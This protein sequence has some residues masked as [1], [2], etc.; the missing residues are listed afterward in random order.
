MENVESHNNKV[1]S[2]YLAALNRQN[3]SSRTIELYGYVL[4][5]FDAGTGEKPVP[6][7]TIDDLELYRL[8][9]VERDMTP[10]S[11]DV[12]MRVVR[13]FF[14]WLEDKQLIFDNPAKGLYLPMP[15]RKLMKVPSEADVRRLLAHPNPATPTGIR[16]RAL[17]ETMYGCGLRR[18]EVLSLTIFNLDLAFGNLRV[19]GK[20]RRERTLPLGRHA[21]RWLKTYV[22]E[23]RQRL[24][25]GAHPVQLQI[26]LGH[27]SVAHLRQ[28]LRLTIKD[29]KQMHSRSK[30]GR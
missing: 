2:D 4:K 24:Q 30:P 19:I 12:Y 27:A 10:A 15:E 22:T 17:L 20:G 6:D 7:I 9:L 29:I 25:H 5:D 16:D 21:V 14:A 3:Y 26:L 23:A 13:K 8:S 11:I 1:I 18:E 28:Y